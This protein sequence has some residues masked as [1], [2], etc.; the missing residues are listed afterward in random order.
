MNGLKLQNGHAHLIS[1]KL[2]ICESHLLVSH[3]ELMMDENLFVL[4]F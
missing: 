2:I 3:D 4:S 1:I